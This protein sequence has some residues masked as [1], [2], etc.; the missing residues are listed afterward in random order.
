MAAQPIDIDAYLAEQRQDVRETLEA[1]RRVIRDE[2]PEVTESISYRMATFKYKGRYLVY[3]GAARNHCGIYSLSSGIER[4]Q[5][6]LAA[7]R[8]AKGTIQVPIGEPLPE[9]LLRTLLR[10][11][12]GE[13]EAAEAGRKAKRRSSR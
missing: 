4:H 8:T 2:V 12:V 1:M 10:E 11:R 13:I 6:E 3:L 9:P 5:A 7:Y